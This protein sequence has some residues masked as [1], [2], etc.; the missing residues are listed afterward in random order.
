MW[1]GRHCCKERCPLP[2]SR[3]SVAKKTSVTSTRSSPPSLRRS[4]LHARFASCLGRTRTASGTS[5]T[6]LTSASG[7]RASQTIFV[8][9][10]ARAEWRC[11]LT[12]GQNYTVNER[13]RWETTRRQ[14]AGFKHPL[15][16]SKLRKIL[17]GVVCHEWITIET[18]S[19]TTVQHT[20]DLFILWTSDFETH[21]ISWSVSVVTGGG[22]CAADCSGGCSVASHTNA[23]HLYLYVIHRNSFVL[24][25]VRVELVLF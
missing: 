8:T 12:V 25:L 3:P 23:L 13:D 19:P 4:R 24:L 17:Y 22:L 11:Q 7:M 10:L 20:S 14:S 6:S 18:T 5:T 21:P 9:L 2:S 1:T 16:K 15:R